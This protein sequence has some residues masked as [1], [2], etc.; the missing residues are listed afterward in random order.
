M[1]SGYDYRILEPI[2]QEI[3]VLCIDPD[4][5]LSDRTPMRCKLKHISLQ[6][7]PVEN[8]LAVSYCWGSGK[9]QA[10]L[11]ID[12][13][14]VAIP[15]TA[16]VAIR[17]L[18]KVSSYPL[19]IDAVCIDQNNPEEK[20]RQVTMMKEIYSKAVSVLIWLGPA[21]RSTADAIAS[22]EK[23]HQQCLEAIDSIE[24]LNTHL[25]GSAGFKYSDE[26]LP[27]SDWSAL[28][29]F[30]SA[31]WF[32]RLWVIQEIGLAKDSTFYVGAFSIGA[33]KVVLAAR[34]MVHRKYTRYCEGR[35]SP[36]VEN[37]SS[38]Y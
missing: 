23:I 30:Y 20:S 2:A 9:K 8:F 1:A 16:A 6:S 27:D 11:V 38:M 37:A 15:R 7:V 31:P 21:Q 26:P 5:N 12:G 35:E 32:G 34:W 17:N 18:S 19:W 14:N 25:Y 22:V 33:E 29:A 36:G 28:Q 4:G 13:H 3:R 24:H 10:P